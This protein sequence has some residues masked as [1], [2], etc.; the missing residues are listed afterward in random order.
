MI[1][2]RGHISQISHLLLY[3]LLWLLVPGLSSQFLPLL[4][5]HPPFNISNGQQQLWELSGYKILKALGN[6]DK[7][8]RLQYLQC[9][10]RNS[11]P[12]I[13]MDPSTW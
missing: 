1:R 3:P 10:I 12:G 5:L 2:L 11:I 4:P 13:F 8:Y 9:K 7:A 6:P